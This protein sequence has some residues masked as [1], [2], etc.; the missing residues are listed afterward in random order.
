[1]SEPSL[2]ILLVDQNA[3][4]AAILDDGLREAGF[5]DI[6]IVREMHSLLRRIVDLDP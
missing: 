6:T 4:R 1:M 3:E 2:R 5:S